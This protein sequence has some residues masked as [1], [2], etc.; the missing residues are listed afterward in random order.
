[1]KKIGDAVNASDFE[2]GYVLADVSNKW[3]C[4]IEFVDHDKELLYYHSVE[5]YDN[6]ETLHEGIIT[7]ERWEE[8]KGHECFPDDILIQILDKE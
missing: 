2:S 6:N 7:F 3:F 8:L 4:V 5:F 1:M